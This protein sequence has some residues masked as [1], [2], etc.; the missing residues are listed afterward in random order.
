MNKSKITVTTKTITM[1]T[2]G[3]MTS[4][5]ST[6]IN[7]DLA[8][9]TTAA[10][11]AFKM[12]RIIKK[13]LGKRRK[14]G[15]SNHEGVNSK[16][17]TPKATMTSGIGEIIMVIVGENS[18]RTGKGF[19]INKANNTKRHNTIGLGAALNLRRMLTTFVTI[20]NLR[21]K[22]DTTMY[23]NISWTKSITRKNTIVTGMKTR[24]AAIETKIDTVDT[25]GPMSKRERSSGRG[26]GKTTGITKKRGNRRT[27]RIEEEERT[28]RG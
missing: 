9:T 16:A 20:M 4:R 23:I 6:K 10:S 2:K 8:G 26:T 15:R 1:I 18:N 25:T 3:K 21:G 28:E 13:K 14:I 12:I 7:A 27:N 11:D 24:K 22:N 17:T 19:S 5:I